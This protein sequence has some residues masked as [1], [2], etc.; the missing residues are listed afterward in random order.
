MADKLREDLNIIQNSGIEVQI[1]PMTKDLNIIQKLDDEPNDVG[2]MSAQELK[3]TFDA[4]GNIIKDY[5]NGTLIPQIKVE[6][7]SEKQRELNEQQRQDNEAQRQANERVRQSNEEARE[8]AAAALNESIEKAETERNVWE[9]YNPEKA[10]VPGNKVYWAGSSYVNKVPCTGVPPNAAEYWQMV[11]KR[12]ET[13]GSGMTREDCDERYLQ[14][15][16]GWMTGPMTVLEPNRPNNPATKQYVDEAPP[17]GFRHMVIFQESGMF[18][19]ADYGLT[20]GSILSL[21]VVGGGG[22][23]GCGFISGSVTES[24]SSN[25]N[26]GDAG[27]DSPDPNVGG[28]A[29]QGYGAGG[30]GGGAISS[31]GNSVYAGDGGWS[32]SVVHRVIKLLSMD[33]IPVTVGSPG[34]GSVLAGNT[35]QEF[36]IVPG[37]NGGSSS[38]G[39]Y[40]STTGGTLGGSYTD[41]GDSGTGYAKGGRRGKSSPVR[42]AGA[43]FGG[44]GGSNGSP[45]EN[46]DQASG[47][48]TGTKPYQI[49]GG[50][51]GGGYII[52]FSALEVHTI[53]ELVPGAG[54]VVAAW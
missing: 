29:G 8:A 1:D 7:I 39:S 11:A 45:G 36:H 51:G 41:S 32:G 50:G 40:A 34:T 14:L 5:I 31:A 37:T 20:V 22:G 18:D 23:G 17:G 49:G 52:P 2:G 38:F 9:N 30:G 48:T 42:R 33:L 19:P 15:S 35:L 43:A 4:A 21:T 47:S 16:G 26:G 27:K 53:G 44:A 24:G 54:V 6:T 3:K 25:W 13:V 10:Y 46:G 12:G 28:K